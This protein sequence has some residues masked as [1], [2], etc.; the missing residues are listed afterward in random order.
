MRSPS[1]PV[2]FTVD[3]AHEHLTALLRDP[4]SVNPPD[5]RIDWADGPWPIKAY[6]GGERVPLGPGRLSRLLNLSLAV[7][8]VRFAPGGLAPT[9]SGRS[10]APQGP[11]LVMRR[12][13]PSGGSMYPTECYV[14][15][16][17][18]RAWH[19]DP[20]RHELTGLARPEA[21]TALRRSL[22]LDERALL[23]VTVLVLTS[24]FWKNFYK[25]GE[26][27]HRLGTI[28]A[29][30]ALGRLVR[31]GRAEYGAVDVRTEFADD[32]LDEGLGLDGR[33][34]SAYA[35][36]G[37]GPALASSGAA[38]N[39][40]RPPVLIERSRRIK[41]S[42]V[43]EAIQTAARRAEPPSPRQ[44]SQE[45]VDPGAAPPPDDMVRRTSNGSLFNGRTAGR[46]ALLSVLRQA[47]QALEELRA[48]GDVPGLVSLH[49]A[50][51]AVEEVTPGWYHYRQ[52]R[53]TL[54]EVGDPA[55]ELQ[56]ALF[57]DNVNIELAAF[58]VHLAAPGDLR[59]LGGA[60][61]HR[62]TQLGV[63]VG[64]EALTLAATSAGLGSHTLLG[65]DV[66]RVAGHYD[67]PDGRAV[68]AQVCVGPVRPTITWEIS[69]TQR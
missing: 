38:V 25:Y 50:V 68:Q 48:V 7:T 54:A 64:I 11:R 46:A 6:A 39:G 55:R 24:R 19:Y 53:L 57:A 60:R 32:V 34:E 22:G 16:S 23:P 40:E 36:I 42:P 41:R 67:L 44:F 5:W 62:Q 12:P 10:A 58:T 17:G 59:P 21:A 43:F 49:C 56:R 20:Y 4:T 69:V 31:L 18:S 9:P 27:A 3:E 66:T 30:V 35:V 1:V 2:T 45:S 15:E 13:I 52:G 65:F 61:V 33:D 28:D 29:G 26:F 63:G 8:R 14:L 51:R 47:E 37:L